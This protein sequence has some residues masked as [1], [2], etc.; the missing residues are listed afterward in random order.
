[1]A[2]TG[3]P[4]F[5]ENY[6][7][8]IQ[9]YF[10]V[11][12]FQPAPNQFAC[13]FTDNTKRRQ[14]EKEKDRLQAQFVQA[15]KM[16]SVGRLAGGV[17]HDYNNMLSVILGYTELA[18]DKVDPSEPLHADLKEILDAA[19]RSTD[20]T[21]QLLAFARKQTIAPKCST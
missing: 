9:K 13:M 1:M 4:A 7:A 3:E 20:I 8:D 15:Q 2:L 21:R 18:L 6:A 19:K 17:A 14:I 10:E 5:F 11:T 16:E 12:A